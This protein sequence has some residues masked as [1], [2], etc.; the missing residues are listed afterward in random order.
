EYL[1]FEK[2]LL[3]ATIMSYKRD[4]AKF[5]DYILKNTNIDFKYITK[6]QIIDFLKYLYSS[7]NE[8]SVSRILSTMRGFYKFLIRHQ[9][10]KENPFLEIK[11]PHTSKKILEILDIDEVEKFL[12]SIPVSAPSDLRNRAMF[13][14][15]YG[16][17]LRVSEITGL[18]TGDIYYEQELLKFIGKGEKE[19][20][21]PIGETA[22]LYLDR[23]LTY[24]RGK[25]EKEFKSDYVFLNCRGRRL[26]RQGFWK[27]LKKYSKKSGIEKNIYPH[28]FRHSFATH[29]L[30]EGADIR[31]VQKLLGHSSIS[32]TEIYTNLNK[33][34]LKDAYFRF[35]PREKS[36]D[37]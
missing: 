13:E 33:E 28:I 5:R 17:G 8:V 2:L 11:N 9:I 24:G 10:I 14:M 22:L 21:V 26:S 30:Q 19:R 3:S 16:C 15:L 35:H 6:P 37:D 23:Y 7:Q 12:E 1:R 36:A 27:I 29:L 32:T 31:V 20:L 25:L 18:R 34:Y 4:L